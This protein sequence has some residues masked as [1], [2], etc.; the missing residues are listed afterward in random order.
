[1]I[2]D[3]Q[4]ITEDDQTAAERR[5]ARAL[6]IALAGDVGA[7]YGALKGSGVEGELL[8]DL[9]RGFQERWIP[10][11]EVESTIYVNTYPGDE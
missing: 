11:D 2:D 3:L 1:M 6:A 10:G 5:E 8:A 4:R 7:F 9:T